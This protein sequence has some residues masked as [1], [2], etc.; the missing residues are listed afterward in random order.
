LT[1]SHVTYVIV[2]HDHGWAYKVGD[3]IS[4]TYLTREA[5]HAAAA[6][7][8]AEQRAPGETTEIQ[9]ETRDGKWRV[10]NARGD[11][12]PETDVKD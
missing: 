1:V 9:F 11:D 3:T 10:E 4:M 8:A 7:A 6:A 12:R 2:Q 5:A